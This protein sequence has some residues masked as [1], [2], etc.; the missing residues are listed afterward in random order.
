MMRGYRKKVEL[1]LDTTAYAEE[2]EREM[3]AGELNLIIL[4]VGSLSNASEIQRSRVDLRGIAGHGFRVVA[5]NCHDMARV[6]L[7]ETPAQRDAD[8]R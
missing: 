5:M 1:C 8:R 6:P 7:M 3:S 4:R 2:C